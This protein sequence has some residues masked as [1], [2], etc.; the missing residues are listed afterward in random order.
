M[1]RK[2]RP[3]WEQEEKCGLGLNACSPCPG[4][5]PLP[6]PGPQPQLSKLAILL[7]LLAPPVQGQQPSWQVFAE[8]LHGTN[9]IPGPK[10]SRTRFLPS[11]GS[12]I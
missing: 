6:H 5:G 12:P 2:R 3:G 1:Q 11:A 4:T 7:G 9:S 8:H 10:T